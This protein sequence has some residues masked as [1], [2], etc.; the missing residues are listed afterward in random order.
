MACVCNIFKDNSFNEEK[1][2]VNERE[3]SLLI[4][5]RTKVDSAYIR[6]PIGTPGR[7]VK[8]DNHSVYMIASLPTVFAA[9]LGVID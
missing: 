7:E 4:Q 8:I 2:I 1:K 6:K 3:M 5:V 9:I